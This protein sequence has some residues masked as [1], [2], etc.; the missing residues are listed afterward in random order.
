MVGYVLRPSPATA[1]AASRTL[2]NSLIGALALARQCV[3]LVRRYAQGGV[4]FPARP[5]RL[6]AAARTALLVPA[7]AAPL[8]VRPKGLPNRTFL[9]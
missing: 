2:L 1:T 9:I 5:A 7:S 3:G 6:P 4:W 8:P